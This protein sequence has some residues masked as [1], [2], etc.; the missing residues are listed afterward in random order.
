[1]HYASITQTNFINSSRVSITLQRNKQLNMRP[2][3]LSILIY[4]CISFSSFAQSDDAIEASTHIPITGYW[5]GDLNFS[6]VVLRIGINIEEGETGLEA[7]MDSPDQGVKDIKVNSVVLQGDS[8]FVNMKRISASYAGVYHHEDSTFVG[9]FTQGEKIPMILKR[10]DGPVVLNRPQEPLPPFPYKTEEVTFENKKEGIALAG[11]ITI[12][13]GA[14]PFPGVVLITGSGPQNRDEEL[15]GHKPFLVLADHLTRNGIAVLRY[16]DRG[17]GMSKGNFY[18]AT[19]LD[20]AEDAGAAFEYLV[21]RDEIDNTKTGLAGH[22]EGGLIAPIVAAGNKN[23]AFVV[24]LAGPGVRGEE[25]LL[26]QGRL[27][28]EAEHVDSMIV[29]ITDRLN[30]EIYTILKNEKDN[31][32]ASIQIRDAYAKHSEGL[33]KEEKKKYG[34]SFLSIT[35]ALQQVTTP[36]FRTFLILEPSKY[37][38]KLKCPVLALN[39]STDLQVPSRQNLD[40]IS[41]ILSQSKCPQYE[42]IEIEGLNHLFQESATGSLS[43]YGKIEQTI[44]PIVLEKTTAWILDLWK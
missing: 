35:S 18:T 11:T 4:I 37:L 25:I 31:E 9:T 15:F 43:E 41:A 3:L 5:L 6:G 12:P 40:A 27:I 33:T 39:G 36:W 19:S 29:D 20:F 7:T 13:E 42:T 10:T 24:L 8:L 1:M 30:R 32:K 16:D 21:S 14:G 34:F 23:V 26:A 44:S 2:I 38:K 28:A 17:V 22:S